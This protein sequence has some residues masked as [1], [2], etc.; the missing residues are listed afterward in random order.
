M[1]QVSFF[2][3]SRTIV[4]V[5]SGPFLSK[6]AVSCSRYIFWQ[7]REKEWQPAGLVKCAVESSDSRSV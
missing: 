6:I 2:A 3:K 5:A 7:R 1:L 4:H